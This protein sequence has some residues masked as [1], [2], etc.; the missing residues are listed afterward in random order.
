MTF[1]IANAS[2]TSNIPPTVSVVVPVRDGAATL[3]AVLTAIA[4]LAPAPLEVIV[5]DD[6]SRDESVAVARSFGA[7]VVE[8][9]SPG[10][11]AAARN[12][13]ARGARGDVVM[14]VD[15]DVVVP[16]S[17]IAVVRRRL[18]SSPGLAGVQGVYAAEPT[19]PTPWTLYQQAYYHHYFCK[20]YDR[21]EA[22]LA[23]YC[24]ALRRDLFLATGGFDET[25]R[26]PTVE[27]E[28]LGYRFH[29]QGYRIRLA[30]ELEVRHLVSYSWRSFARRRFRMVAAQSRMIRDDPRRLANVLGRH[31]HHP[32]NVLL[33]VALL[34]LLA[35]SLLLGGWAP[36]WAPL[37]W[38]LFGACHLGFWD[39]VRQRWGW[40][41]LLQVMGITL[42][43]SAVIAV[44]GV[45]GLA[46]WR[47]AAQ[48]PVRAT[49]S[50]KSEES[51]CA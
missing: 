12:A 25:L 4:E 37:P 8:V 51:P 48:Q 24:T 7:T 28:H 44:A 30:P 46:G 6:G 41:E 36:D 16:P 38:M 47:L 19:Y 49:P 17:A 20:V 21:T 14:L 43:D 5:A 1:R 31:G 34:P 27:D 40:R 13:G 29:D 18:A 42:L 11:P 3:P 2:V 45:G 26:A 9:A 32:R 39:F 22:V 50:K 15:A 10:G 33:G 35:A 23:T